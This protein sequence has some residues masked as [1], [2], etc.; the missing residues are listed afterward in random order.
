VHN[1]TSHNMRTFEVPGIGGI[2]LAPDTEEHR[3]FF[4]HEKEVFLYTD[5]DDCVTQI[6]KIIGLS[7]EKADN[8]RFEARKRSVQSG[9][10]YKDRTLSVSQHLQ[11]L[12]APDLHH[13]F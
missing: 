1:P 12:Y 13:S 5:V 7:K 4:T 8:I 3:L 2:L 9:Y 10:S 6:N 11:Q